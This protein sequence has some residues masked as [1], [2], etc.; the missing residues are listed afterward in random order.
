[1]GLMA[2]EDLFELLESQAAGSARTA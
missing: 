1:V 2:R